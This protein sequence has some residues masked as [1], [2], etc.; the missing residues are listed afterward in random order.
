VFADL[1]AQPGVVE[2]LTLGSR[3]GFLAFHGGSLERM[4]DVIAREAAARSGASY[5]GVLLPEG[6]HWHIPSKLVDPAASP[7]L[8]EL[9]D[10]VDVALAVHGYGRPDRWTTI[11]LGGGNRALA[12]HLATHLRPALPEYTI[13][14]DLTEVPRE[15]HG[16][17]PDNPV[18]R[19]RG[20]GVQ[21]ELPPRVRGMGPF[22]ADHAGDG[23]VPH[24]EA[25]IEGLASAARS[26]PI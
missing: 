17:H 6:L 15:L 20:G 10:H 4:T 18:N 12:D 9:L 25:L 11:L 7:R 2:E 5:Y 19:A 23:L 26:W 21:V 1:L 14:A 8:A 16:L 3:V 22:W 13:V 24:T